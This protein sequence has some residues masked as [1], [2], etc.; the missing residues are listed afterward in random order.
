MRP[1]R[2]SGSPAAPGPRRRARRGRRVPAPPRGADV[3]PPRRRGP[4]GRFQR[5]WTPVFLSPSLVIIGGF[6]VVPIGLTAWI[7]LHEWSMLTPFGDMTFVGLDNYAYALG[8]R[9][10]RQALLNT[11][12]YTGLTVALIVPLALG[13]GMLLFLPRLVG[14]RALRTVLF[15][16]YMIPPVAVAIIWS[17]L[18]APLHGPLNQMLTA[19]GLPPVAW[20]GS[21]QTALYSLVA[22][23]VWQ[24]VGYFTVLVIAGLTQIPTEYY[25]AAAVD[26][27]GALRQTRHVTIPLLRRT[28][29]FVVVMAIINSVQVF[30]PIYV[31]T[32]GGPAGSTNVLSFHIYRTA[33]DFGLAGRASSMAVIM[34]LVLVVAVGAVLRAGRE[35]A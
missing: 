16:T 9:V 23:N 19:V 13:L 28:L 4:A 25:D 18:Y 21:T 3:A 11:V 32:Q 20:L 1:P 5:R 24:L 14:Q 7:S 26:G 34:L 6:I 10:F 12:I 33:F 17:S 15:A 35:P 8:D 29:V 2:L 27:A 30:D 22:F 31:L